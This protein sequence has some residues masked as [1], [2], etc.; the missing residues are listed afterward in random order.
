MPRGYRTGP[1]G[2]GQMISRSLGYCAGNSD[3]DYQ[4]GDFF[5]CGLGRGRSLGERGL[6]FR[7]GAVGRGGRPFA[8]SAGVAPVPSVNKVDRIKAQIDGLEMSL[9]AIKQ[10]LLAVED[11]PE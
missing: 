6:A 8:P 1:L 9:H 5:G 11:D 10:R 3:S 2:K 4:S 7:N